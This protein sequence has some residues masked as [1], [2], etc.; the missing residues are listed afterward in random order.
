VLVSNLFTIESP[1]DTMGKKDKMKGKQLHHPSSDEVTTSTPQST[2]SEHSPKTRQ[3]TD[4]GSGPSGGLLEKPRGS[5]GSGS[6]KGRP[7]SPTSPMRSPEE[8]EKARER[9]RHLNYLCVQML[10]KSFY[11]SEI[12]AWKGATV[13]ERNTQ[14]RQCYAAIQ[15]LDM[16]ELK[17]VGKEIGIS[18]EGDDADDD[19]DKAREGKFMDQ[20]LE[21]LQLEYYPLGIFSFLYAL[22]RLCA[23][24]VLSTWGLILPTLMGVLRLTHPFFRM[25]GVPQEL[26][27]F[28]M[29][30]HLCARYWL[31][32]FGVELE[33]EGQENLGDPVVVCMYNH[34]TALDWHIG[35]ASSLFRVAFRWIGKK[36][37]LMVPGIGWFMAARGDQPLDRENREKSIAQLKELA[38]QRRSVCIAPEG[39]RSSTGHIALEF[40]KGPFYLQKDMGNCPIQPMCVIGSW[41][42]QPSIM[43]LP[44]FGRVKVRFLETLYVNENRPMDMLRRLVRQRMIEGVAVNVDKDLNSV[45]WSFFLTHLFVV[46]PFFVFHCWFTYAFLDFVYSTAM[47]TDWWQVLY[48]GA[49]L[50]SEVL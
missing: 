24:I 28:W 4:G 8:V 35:E 6:S 30:S 48:Q 37:L 10:W 25:L 36:S 22:V 17:M 38:E 44:R 18:Y 3:Q 32:M 1:T 13:S 29:F 21:V 33:I 5:S 20:W 41:E 45:S 14:R 27:P 26:F 47:T 50:L 7:G 42:V 23:I 43:S 12:G 31:F 11:D 40:K 34:C 19:E 2:P 9:G 15:T 49:D 46:W 16:K 39:T